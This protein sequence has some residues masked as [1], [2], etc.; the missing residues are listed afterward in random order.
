MNRFEQKSMSLGRKLK[1]FPW[2]NFREE[3]FAITVSFMRRRVQ[4]H[5]KRLDCGAASD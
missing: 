1:I 5:V 3:T 2:G 4:R